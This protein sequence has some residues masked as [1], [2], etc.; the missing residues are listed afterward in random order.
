M[1]GFIN[2][3]CGAEG[4]GG[5]NSDSDFEEGGDDGW[6]PGN[7]RSRGAGRGRVANRIGRGGENKFYSHYYSHIGIFIIARLKQTNTQVEEWDV[8]QSVKVEF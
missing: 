5:D 2:W 1:A 6:R 4:G 7:G 8:A 3:E